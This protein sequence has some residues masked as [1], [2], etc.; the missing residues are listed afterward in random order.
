LVAAPRKR[1]QITSTRRDTRIGKRL[2]KLVNRAA[3]LIR[4]SLVY[5]V[6]AK[7]RPEEGKAFGIC[8]ANESE[9]VVLAYDDT[10]PFRER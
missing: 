5:G 7:L 6:A 8:F 1:D 3:N 9:K 10:K 2:L 4:L